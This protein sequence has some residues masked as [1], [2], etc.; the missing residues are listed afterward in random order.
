MRFDE[1]MGRVL[2]E[3]GLGYYSG[4]SRKFGAAGDFVTAP[5]LSGFFGGC[6]AEQLA[7]WFDEG[8]PPVVYE[9]GAGSG[10]LA[11][12]VIET[13]TQR[14]VPLQ[15]RI[16]EVSGELRERQRERIGVSADKSGAMNV[17]WLDAL[18]ERIDGVV[19]GN[20]VLDAMPVR[21]FALNDGRVCERGVELAPDG[22]LFRF[23]DRPAGPSFEARV[24]A[25]LAASGWARQGGWPSPYVS[26]LGEQA[27]AWVRSVGARLGHGALLLADYGFPAAEFYHPQ[28]DQGTLVCHYRHR[29][30]SDPF[31]MPGL[32]DISAHV[33]F[34]A[35]AAAAQTVGLDCLGYVSQARFLMSCG[36]L[37]QV[38]A[39]PLSDPVQR[40]RLNASLQQLLMESEMGELLKFIAFGR[41]LPDEAIGFAAGDRRGVLQP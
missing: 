37:E 13:L 7:Q 23:V 1:W 21:L 15:Y 39:Q 3:P 20:E 24:R 4:G 40:A 35:V 28:R 29:V 16:L 19:L 30:H 9:F 5:E 27:S 26:E 36:L 34:S 8:V 6:I 10:T 11:A 14:G 31:W 18:P 22:S 2:Y 38:A 17:A 33:D 41:G 12:Q 32:Q 25:A